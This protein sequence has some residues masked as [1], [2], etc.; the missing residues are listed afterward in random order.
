MRFIADGPWLPDEL[1][2]ARDAGQVIFFCGAGVSQA[3]AGLPNFAD[4]A[5][6]VLSS[7]GSSLDSPA[8]RLFEAGR[9]FE[10]TSGLTGLVATDRIFGLLEREFDVAEVRAAVAKEL[11]PRTGYSLDAHRTV[12][13]LSRDR[14]GVARLVTTN[15]DLLFEACDPALG[16]FNP[17][18]LPDPRRVQDFRGI[19]HIHGRVDPTY[20]AACDDEFVLSSADFG[21]AYLADGWATRYIQALLR[22]YKIVFLGYSA[23]DPPVQYLLEALSRSGERP[24]GLY[25]FQAGD[26]GQAS[27]QWAHK[28][29]TPIPYESSNRHAMLWDTLRAWAGR[30]RNVDAWADGVIAAAAAGPETMLPHERGVIAH[31]AA[32]ASGAK[33]LATA[34]APPPATWLCVLDPQRRYGDPG[35]LSLDDY[36]GARFD[37]FE[38]FGLDSDEPPPPMDPADRIARRQAPEG[39]WDPFATTD[40]DREN[41]PAEGAGRLRGEAASRSPKLPTRLWHLGMYLLRVAH[42][43]AALWWAAHQSGLHPNVRAQLEWT[44]RR[45][46]ARF[47]EDMRRGWRLLLTAWDEPT[48]DSDRVRYSLE[49]VAQQDGWSGKLVRDVVAIYRPFIRVRPPFASRAPANSLDVT[50]EQTIRA[51]VEYPRP[52]LPLPVPADHLAYACALYRAQ[53]EYAVALE[54]ELSGRDEIYLD[55]IRADDDEELDED[56][57]KLTGL[58]ATFTNMMRRLVVE[59]PQAARAE[60]ERW[61][62][63]QNALFTRL[64]IWAASLPALVPGEEAAQ[65]FLTLDELSFWTHANERDLLFGLRDRWND[66]SAQ[67]RQGIEQRLLTGNFPWEEPKENATAINAHYRLNRLEWL[68]ARGVAFSFDVDAEIATIRQVATDWEPRFAARAG[69]PQVGPARTIKSDTDPSGLQGLPIKSIL[70]TARDASSFDFESSVERRPFSGLAAARPA[71]ALAVL[72]DA[73][74]RGEFP[75][76]EWATL[77]RETSTGDVTPRLLRTLGLRLARLTPAQISELQHPISDWLHDRRKLLVADIPHVF[78][79]VWAA[80]VASLTTHPPGQRF[81]RQNHGWLSEALNQPAGRMARTVF[82]A[83]AVNSCVVGQGLPEP[84]KTRL[85]QLLALPGDGRRHAIA[86]A[87]QHL[88][89]LYSVDPTWTDAQLVSLA[90]SSDV[91]SQAFWSGYL[92]AGRTPQPQ[93]YQRLVGPFIALAGSP[94]ISRDHAN[95]V[96]GMLLAGW[97]ADP[98]ILSDVQM[99]E[100]LIQGTDELRSQVLWYLWRWCLEPDS[101]WP[102]KLLPFLRAVWP[103]QLAVKTPLTIGRLIDLALGMPSRFPEIVEVILPRLAGG[104]VT[105]RMALLDVEAGIAAQH[106]KPLLDLL[107]TVLPVDTDAWPYEIGKVLDALSEQDATRDDSRLLELMRRDPRR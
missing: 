74:R 58:V 50:L 40:A 67:D 38:A 22:H 98:P 21:R 83:E 99:R 95:K 60:L 23:D 25:A 62:F 28:G 80:L 8:R 32:T 100:V 89:W 46:P 107:W 15:F 81:R 53:L 17:P 10:T 90:D 41:L 19:M 31:L 37:P 12:L 69:Q 105:A 9:K 27:A 49:A 33:A 35:P 43:P 91:D 29:V 73:N 11:A 55:S 70:Q 82:E 57:Y 18:H 101:K 47:S 4:L 39:A 88:N 92:M 77:I 30:A 75:L 104:N 84:W 72:T 7:L 94:T 6:G 61:P 34:A 56:G 97:G 106:P 44:L 71:L 66:M 93:L 51:E 42:Q 59:N 14:A 36:D 52:H 103:K 3:G 13:D 24:N 64:Q 96:G 54:R 87:S 68:R 86:T 79:A 48:S 85:D 20:S 2:A 65:I 78:D 1:L 26:I 45:E 76:H 63:C 102:D 5:E 16:S